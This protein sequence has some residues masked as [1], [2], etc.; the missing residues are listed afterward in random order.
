LAAFGTRQEDISKVIGVSE[1][2][3]RKHFRQ[4]LDRAAIDTNTQV[5]NK[6]QTTTKA[7]FEMKG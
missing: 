1:R 6:T 4:E 2:T 5:S 7:M 3:L